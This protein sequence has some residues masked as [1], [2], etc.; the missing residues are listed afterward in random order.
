[1]LRLLEPKKLRLL[2]ENRLLGGEEAEFRAAPSKYETPYKPPPTEKEK[3]E[4]F[5]KTIGEESAPTPIEKVAQFA[6][7]TK[8]I[9]ETVLMAP[10]KIFQGLRGVVGAV[11]PKTTIKETLRSSALKGLAEPEKTPVMGESAAKAYPKAPWQLTGTMGTLAEAGVLFGLGMGGKKTVEAKEAIKGFTAEET[12][13]LTTKGGM[14]E[15]VKKYGVQKTKDLRAKFGQFMAKSAGEVPKPVTE[16][17]AGVPKNIID[18][19]QLTPEQVKN[20]QKGVM[21]GIPAGAIAEIAKA[22]KAPSTPQG[23]EKTPIVD[24]LI[25][26][27]RKYKTAEEFAARTPFKDSVKKESAYHGTPK[28]GFAEFSKEKRGLR[29]G[30]KPEDVAFHFTDERKMARAYSEE[31]MEE[32]Y[33]EIEEKLGYIPEG[34]KKPRKD[35]KSVV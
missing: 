33:K 12:K 8:P 17:Y 27:T 28:G 15:F 3:A 20:I 16:Y 13:A 21:T 35:R 25:A 10:W 6:E 34:A 1:M 18:K 11:E 4:A 26:E 2:D 23:I 30:H 9:S 22:E 24:P 7:R 29:T 14:P 19:F 31:Y 5:L 32:H